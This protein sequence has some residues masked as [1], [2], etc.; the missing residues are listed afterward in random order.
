M[1]AWCS[2]EYLISYIFSA[3]LPDNVKHRIRMVLLSLPYF[4]RETMAIRH[5]RAH[6]Y[7]L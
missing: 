1:K 4:Q 7:D 2:Y 5:F 3:I 6:L